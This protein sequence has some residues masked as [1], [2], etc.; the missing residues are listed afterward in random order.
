MIYY[1]IMRNIMRR[2]DIMTFSEKVKFVRGKLLL[3]QKALADEIGVS[4]VTVA[5]WESQGLEPQFLT[6][7]KFEAFCE[8]N[9]INFSASDNN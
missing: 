8:K 7:K 6:K 2:G 9:G 1:D 3:S 4:M 5:R